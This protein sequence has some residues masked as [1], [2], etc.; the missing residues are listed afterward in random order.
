MNRMP[1]HLLLLVASLAAVL[2]VAGICG[3]TRGHASTL[4]TSVWL[5]FRDKEG[6]E[7]NLARYHDQTPFTRAYHDFVETY[8]RYLFAPGPL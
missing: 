2:S 6:V 4:R 5:L 8:A 7:E 3:M 1:V